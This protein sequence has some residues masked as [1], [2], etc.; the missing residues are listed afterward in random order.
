[1]AG[2]GGGGGCGGCGSDMTT[3][4]VSLSIRPH[5]CIELVAG[6][7]GVRPP[8]VPATLGLNVEKDGGRKMPRSAAKAPPQTLNI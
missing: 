4:N 2:D 6:H 3:T 7:L 1:M 5:A 8:G